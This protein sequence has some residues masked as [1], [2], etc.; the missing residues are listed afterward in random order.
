MSMTGCD[1]PTIAKDI[2]DEADLNINIEITKDDYSFQYDGHVNE[3]TIALVLLAFERIKRDL[4]DETEDND[5]KD[6]RVDIV[7]KL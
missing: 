6:A 5:A 1:K 7:T 4:L 2:D 3:R